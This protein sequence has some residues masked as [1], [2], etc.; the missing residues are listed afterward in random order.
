MG[1]FHEGKISKTHLGDI[2]QTIN[3]KKVWTA[4]ISLGERQV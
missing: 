4:K 2:N 1:G 3:P